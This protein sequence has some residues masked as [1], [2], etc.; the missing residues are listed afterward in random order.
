MSQR[1]IWALYLTGD[2]NLSCAYCYYRPS[3]PRGAMTEETAA[4]AVDFA[5]AHGA[6]QGAPSVDIG[7]FGREPLTR[8]DLI[9][10]VVAHAGARHPRVTFSLNTNGTLLTPER[11]DFFGGIKARI[12]L[13]LDGQPYYHDMVRP[14][15]DGS[16]SYGKIAPFFPDL[17]AYD[18]AIYVRMTVTAAGA[19]HFHDNAVHLFDLGFSKVGFSFDLTD[20]DWDAP[21]LGALQRSMTQL[22][23][24]YAAEVDRG[25]DIR[26]P[27]FDS[28]ARGR[29]VPPRGLFCGAAGHLFAVDCDGLVYPCWR[30]VGSAADAMGDVRTGWT[31][32]P[33]SHA[34]NALSQADLVSCRGCG[35]AAYCGRCAWVSLRSTG[36]PDR[37][38][39]A[40]C[41]TARIAIEAG[42]RACDALAAWGSPLFVRRLTGMDAEEAQDGSLVLSDETGCLYHIP[43]G[44]LAKYLV[45]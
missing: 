24:W 33:G 23:D 42:L 11:L 41:A 40:Q 21:A 10:A 1:Q 7:F 15:L 45:K 43:P 6:A 28:L 37:V 38:G 20:P 35:H 36:A 14:A 18:P 22:A 30:F 44:E 13:S 16:S 27:A 32:P 8:F 17:A 19:R 2:C 3:S 34:F 31:A 26:I 5:A 39:I 9:E 29:R 4:R 25:R 12:A